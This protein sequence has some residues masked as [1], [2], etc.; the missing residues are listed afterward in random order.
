[1]NPSHSMIEPIFNS[2]FVNIFHYHNGP[3]QCQRTNKNSSRQYQ[4]S[5]T[6][7]QYH[8]RNTGQR[9]KY[10]NSSQQYQPISFQRSRTSSI[11]YLKEIFLECGL[12]NKGV[13][14]LVMQHD[15]TLYNC[16][17]I[18]PLNIYSKAPIE[19][20][21]QNNHKHEPQ[22]KILDKNIYT[23]KNIGPP[24]EKNL[25]FVQN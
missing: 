16:P 2:N 23:S 5:K 6:R 3:N 11:P 9:H 21:L 10:I 8:H 1:M 25:S 15:G 19:Q 18:V 17:F 12:N 7:Q 20:L 22:T 14:E 4:H 13:R 24:Q